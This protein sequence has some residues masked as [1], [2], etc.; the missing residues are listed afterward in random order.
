MKFLSKIFKKDPV[1]ALNEDL[2]NI[3]VDDKAINFFEI[4]PNHDKDLVV[5]TINE[6]YSGLFIGK[7][8]WFLP[9][10]QD[11]LSSIW[12]ELIRGPVNMTGIG[13]NWGLN[14][15]R[16]FLYLQYKAKEMDIQEP[17]FI[18]HDNIL[19]LHSHIRRIWND[20]LSTIDY[21]EENSL[22]MLLDNSTIDRKYMELFEKEVRKLFKLVES[23]FAL[24]EDEIIRKKELIPEYIG[25]RIPAIWAEGKNMLTYLEIGTMFGLSDEETSDIIQHLAENNLLKNTTNYPLDE[26]LKPRS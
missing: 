4:L 23:E 24:G 9:N 1:E 8:G 26:I 17:V 16:V 13:K 7:Q 2:E 25:E 14:E 11:R 6:K 22:G 21:E 12:D 15:K 3:V 5:K 10:A 19:F 20:T 18:R